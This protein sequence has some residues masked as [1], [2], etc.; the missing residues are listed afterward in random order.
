MSAGTDNSQRFMSRYM[1]GLFI[2]NVLS[3]F[4]FFFVFTCYGGW[5]YPCLVLCILLCFHLLWGLGLSTSSSVYYPSFCVHIF[6]F[7]V[8]INASPRTSRDDD[9][10]RS[11]LCL[12]SI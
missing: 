1:S 2:G 7:L 4:H 11:N 8:W 6:G 5:G 12:T 10:S 9:A 3:V